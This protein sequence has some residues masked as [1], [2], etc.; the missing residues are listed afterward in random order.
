[1]NEETLSKGSIAKHSF[2]STPAYTKRLSKT[3]TLPPLPQKQ[4]PSAPPV[5]SHKNKNQDYEDVDYI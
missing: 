2:Q 1:M 3:D 4:Q 5:P